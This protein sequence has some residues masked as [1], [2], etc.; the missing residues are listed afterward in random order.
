MNRLSWPSISNHN[1]KAVPPALATIVVVHGWL[2]NR[3]DMWLYCRRLR[4]IG[5]EVINWRYPST[6]GSIEDHANSLTLFVNELESKTKR[7]Q[8]HLAGHSMGGLVIRRALHNTIPE[9][10]ARVVMLASPNGGSFMARRLSAWLNW[11]SPTLAEMSD[12]PESYVNQLD[13]L[14]DL[15][16]GVI[17]AQ[18]D[19][20][21]SPDRVHLEGETDFVT[22]PS[23]HGVMPW[24]KIAVT[25]THRF[26]MFGQFDMPSRSSN[27]R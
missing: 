25:M 24:T 27:N 20:V 1:K 18:R 10:L 26:L 21:I 6:K 19:R 5:Y 7:S 14:E 17:A 11:F 15:E 13:G 4:Q 8:I 2:S 16:V 22:I 3:L 23:G 12:C 9:K